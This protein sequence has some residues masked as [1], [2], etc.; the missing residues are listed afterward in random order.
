MP[1]KRKVRS[2]HTI[3]VARFDGETADGG[4]DEPIDLYVTDA[5]NKETVYVP[6]SIKD[7]KAAQKELGRA[8]RAAKTLIVPKED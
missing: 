8:I 5:E 2:S 1:V 3:F 4:N 6:L 7:A